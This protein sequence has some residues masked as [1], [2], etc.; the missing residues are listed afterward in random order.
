M[1]HV[2]VANIFLLNYLI[3]IL[4]TVYELMIVGG[5]FSYKSYKYK[6]I[7]KY[8]VAMQQENRYYEIVI[9]PPPLNVLT[10]LIYP[11]MCK[12]TLMRGAS[13]IFSKFIYW[14]ENIVYIF[15]FIVGEFLTC[16]IVYI[17]QIYD[18]I[19]LVAFK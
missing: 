16:P 1:L 19:R 4:A 9:H 11:F 18:I 12:D 10:V 6:F 13:E 7:E 3:A 8:T 17:K 5:E 14:L 15:L 2:F